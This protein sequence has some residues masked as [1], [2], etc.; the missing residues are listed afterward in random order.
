MYGPEFARVYDHVYT[1]R[2]KDYAGETADLVK[3]IRSRAPGA[4]SLLDVGCG[5]GGHLVH[6]A[7]LFGEV[8]GLELSPDMLAVATERLP[9]TVLHQ[10]DMRAFDTG[11][12]YDAVI[13]LF[14]TIGHAYTEQEL[15]AVFHGFARHLRPGGVVVT[16]PWWFVED[17]IDGYIS[18][19]V[20]EPDGLTV[21]RVS[22]TR[23]DGDSSRMEVHYLVSDAERGTRHFSESYRHRLYTREQYEEA[24]RDAG[25]A[26]E[27]VPGLAQGRG[28]FV[29]VRDA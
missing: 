7:G 5:T 9:D 15:R 14:G 1:L 21:A 25:F 23:R 28:L 19:D 24:Q 4:D 20:I 13:S 11:R 16:E 22:H 6:L 8:E 10:G 29:A 26:T 2:G 12:R 3:L 27:Y 17:F 18:A